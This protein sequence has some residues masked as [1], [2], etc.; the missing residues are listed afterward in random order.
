MGSS[1]SSRKVD[2]E[3]INSKTITADEPLEVQLS[4]KDYDSSVL[5]CEAIVGVKDAMKLSHV[6]TKKECETVV[7]HMFPNQKKYSKGHT[8][9]PI[10][11]RDWDENPKEAY[12]KIGVRIFTHSDD[13]A[14][15]VYERVKHLLP[16]TAETFSAKLNRKLSWKIKGLHPRIRFVCY[17]KGQ[18]FPPHMDD[19]WVQSDSVTT[20][21]TFV[22]Y[23]SDSGDS[24]GCK[25]SGG[26][27]A[28][29][30]PREQYKEVPKEQT[31]DKDLS[32]DKDKDLP[33]DQYKEMAPPSDG[34]KEIVRIS[35]EPGMV[36]IFPHKTLHEA[37]EIISGVKFCI[38]SDI[39][40]ELVAT[41]TEGTPSGD[42]PNVL[43]GKDEGAI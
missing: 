39:V 36:I 7:H 42:V 3:S 18:A 43:E 41:E 23:L 16:Q 20:I 28:F 14:L 4:N 9:T 10:L 30:Q 25:F 38:R 22:I 2:P 32:L 8:A 35:P 6:L 37:K 12:K 19:P 33:L 17:E 31:K 11:F 40:Y 1:S 29:L 26:E 5:T 21:Y 15:V 27:L 13:F 34:F 24:K